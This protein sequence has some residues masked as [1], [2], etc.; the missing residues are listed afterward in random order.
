MRPRENKEL[1]KSVTINLEPSAIEFILTKTDGPISKW[2]RK[3]VQKEIES[4]IEF[5]AIDK[6][7]NKE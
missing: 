2:I 4:I 5:D 6:L 3:L 7:L 1:M